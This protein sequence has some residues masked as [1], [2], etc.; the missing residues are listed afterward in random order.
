MQKDRAWQ[1]VNIWQFGIL[2]NVCYP[3]GYTSEFKSLKTRVL[4]NTCMKMEFATM[5]RNLK[6]LVTLLST[7]E[8]YAYWVNES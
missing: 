6:L 8:K 2:I 3:N 7:C 5:L 4:T 1:I